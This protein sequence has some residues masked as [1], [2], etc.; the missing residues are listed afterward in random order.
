M[1][2]LAFQL[3]SHTALYEDDNEHV[4]KTTAYVTPKFHL[5]H[6]RK[7]FADLEKS[8]HP[9]QETSHSLTDE[10]QTLSPGADAT[11]PVEEP[12]TEEEEEEQPQL[13]VWMSLGLL[14]VITVV[15]IFISS[16]F[17]SPLESV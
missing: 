7:R 10:P 8:R 13:N 17:L 2:Y 3:Y 5:R 6:I 14:V 16:S 4:V 11:F 15:C 12:R 9:I 1:G